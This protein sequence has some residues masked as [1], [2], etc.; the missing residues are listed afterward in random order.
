MQTRQYQAH[1]QTAGLPVA[2]GDA[3]ATF[4][5]ACLRGQEPSERAASAKGARRRAPGWRTGAGAAAVAPPFPL[6]SSGAALSVRIPEP[7]W[8]GALRHA[9][10]G[11]RPLRLGVGKRPPGRS[12]TSGGSPTALLLRLQPLDPLE[13]K[14]L[15]VVSS[16]S[17]QRRFLQERWPGRNGC[18]CGW[19][20]KNPRLF[21]P[22]PR[23]STHSARVSPVLSSG[24]RGRPGGGTRRFQGWR[25]QSFA[26]ASSARASSLCELQIGSWFAL[27][28]RNLL[29]LNWKRKARRRGRFR[30]WLFFKPRE[31]RRDLPAALRTCCI[32]DP[33]F[34]MRALAQNTCFMCVYACWRTC[35]NHCQKHYR[36]FFSLRRNDRITSRIQYYP[37]RPFSF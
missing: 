4:P 23:R 27:R 8:S 32:S 29:K 33:L 1:S 31:G 25:F 13:G 34:D 12:A 36:F 35:K 11:G 28:V 14:T 6:P 2:P 21:K 20:G 9:R 5:S 17:G 30:D 16:Q 37:G 26:R 24:G 22:P 18:S 19:K 10:H 3:P 7:G 15:Y